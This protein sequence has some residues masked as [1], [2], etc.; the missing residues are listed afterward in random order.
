MWSFILDT[1]TWWLRSSEARSSVSSSA[2]SGAEV[3]MDS[4]LAGTPRESKE[5]VVGTSVP[6]EA[7]HKLEPYA[8]QRDQFPQRGRQVVVVSKRDAR[9]TA[10]HYCCWYDQL[11]NVMKDFGWEMFPKDRMPARV[12]SLHRE[13]RDYRLQWRLGCRCGPI[14]HHVLGRAEEGKSSKRTWARSGVHPDDGSGRSL[15]SLSWSQFRKRAWTAA[16]SHA[17]RPRSKGS[18]QD[19][20][21]ARPRVGDARSRHWRTAAWSGFP[22]T[23]RAL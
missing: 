16:C 11:T 10:D 17:W 1:R 9:K 22:P 5:M 14:R 8:F 23:R 2:R 7:G 12:A 15:S 4:P 20:T 6:R 3:L 18:H 19:R 21:P 13:D